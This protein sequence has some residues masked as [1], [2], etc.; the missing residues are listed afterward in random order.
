VTL[1]YARDLWTRAR[2]ALK[3][4]ELLVNV[5]AD[6]AASRAYYAAF[7]AVSAAFAL[8]DQ[9]FRRHGAVR[10][11]VHREWVKTGIWSVDLGAD[12]D[13]I[14]EL[15]DMGDYGGRQHVA[16]EDAVAAVEAARRILDAVRLRFPDLA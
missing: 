6:D 11:A 7:H 12:F 5:S 16:T 13:A 1:D 4:A 2:N 3:S 14:W 10:A 15:R 8:R 9:T